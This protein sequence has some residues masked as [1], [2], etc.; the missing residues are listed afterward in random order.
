MKPVLD[1]F[2]IIKCV[3]TLY[4]IKI[5]WYIRYIYLKINKLFNTDDIMVKLVKSLEVLI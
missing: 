1:S 3:T 2:K 4:M 5:R